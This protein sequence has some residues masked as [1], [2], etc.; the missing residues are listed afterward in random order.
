MASYGLTRDVCYCPSN[1]ERW[2][3][4]SFWAHLDNVH[5]I[6]AYAYTRCADD[7]RGHDVTGWTARNPAPG[8]GELVAPRRL[9]DQPRWRELW[10]DNTRTYPGYGWYGP[11]MRRGAN[12]MIDGNPEPDGLHAGYMDGH[13]RWIPFPQAKM[14]LS[15]GWSFYW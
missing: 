2:N 10:L 1:Y 15:S 3:F 13:A 7:W 5:S 11:D 12:H 4:D 14:R 9:S 8:P 6:W